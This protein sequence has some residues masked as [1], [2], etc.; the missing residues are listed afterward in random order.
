MRKLSIVIPAYNEERFIRTLL[1][2]IHQVPLEHIGFTKEI[3]VVDDGSTDK[4]FE[5]AS[6]FPGV[7][8]LRQANQGKGA[9]VQKGISISTGDYVIVQDADL[10]YDP[11]D[12]MVMLREIKDDKPL[13][14]YGSRPLGIWRSG[15]SCGLPGKHRQQAWGPWFANVVLSLWTGLLYGRRIT[16]PLTAYK[17]YPLQILR[18]MNVKT[19]GFETDHELTAK[20]AKMGIPIK[21]VPIAYQPRSVEEGKKIRARDGLIAVWTLL[22]FRFSN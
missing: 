20:L 9:A 13:V 10:E 8:C 11:Q 17:L 3:I 14:V 22:K 18:R 15:T 12:Y 19:H 4:T 6:N 2:Q 5:L 16:D 21:E 1:E 7:H